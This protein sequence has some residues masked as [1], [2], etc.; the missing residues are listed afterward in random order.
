MKSCL[1]LRTKLKLVFVYKF[2]SF[3]VVIP[4]GPVAPVAPVAPV[5]PGRP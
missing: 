2:V 4:D 1:P 5:E 3:N